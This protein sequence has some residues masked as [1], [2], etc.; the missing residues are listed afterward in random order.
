M[1]TETDP[2]RVTT[3]G[4]AMVPDAEPRPAAQGE[5]T[6]RLYAVRR[7]LVFGGGGVLT[8]LVL[9]AAGIAGLGIVEDFHGR[10]RQSFSEANAAI[11]YFLLQRDRAYAMSINSNDVIWHEQRADLEAKGAPLAPQFHAN[12][13]QLVVRAEGRTAVPWLVLGLPDH[14]VELTT[15]NA[16]L[17]MLDAYSAYTATAV[18][19]L[20]STG[21]SLT[22][23]YEP[24]GRLLAVSHMRDEAQLLQTLGVATRQQA[25]ALLLREEALVRHHPIRSGPIRSASASGRLISRY[26][27]NPLNGQPSLVGIL[28]LAEGSTP[29]FRRVVFESVDTMKARLAVSEHGNFAVLSNE[30]RLIFSNGQWSQAEATTAAAWTAG[31]SSKT[32][33]RHYEHGQFIVTGL[34]PDTDWVLLQAYDWGDIWDSQGTQLLITLATALLIVALLWALLL[35]MDRRIFAPALL[36][37]SRVYESDALSGAIISTAPIGLALIARDSGTPLL[38][39]QAAHNLISALRSATDATDPAPTLYADL[40]AH[41]RNTPASDAINLQWSAPEAP[42][43]RPIQLQVSLAPASYLEKPV[44]VCAFHDV[45]DQLEFADNLKRARADSERARELAEAANRAKSAF[46]ATMS[47]EI[48]TPLNG[49]LGHLELLARAELP[50]G[51]RERVERIRYSAD[52]LMS[53]ISDVLDFSKIEAGQLDLEC[54]PFALRPLL[55]SVAVLFAPEAARKGVKLY[56]ALEFPPYQQVSGDSHRI[57]QILNNLVGNAVKFTEAGRIL[58]RA[59]L[60]TNT[61]G[62]AHLCVEVIDSGIGISAEQLQQ[63]FQPFQQA[64]ASVSR[65]YG[66][67]GLGLALCQQLATA[68]GGR[69]EAD[70][71]P[72]VGSRFTLDIPVEALPLAPTPPPL[73]GQA[74]IVLAANQEWRG[75]FTRLLNGWGAEVRGLEHASA[76]AHDGAD[77]TLLIVGERSGFTAEEDAALRAHYDRILRLSGNGP[78]SPERQSD[79][80]IVLSAFVSDA[81]LQVLAPSLAAAPDATAHLQPVSG[82]TAM[83]VLLAEDN[84]VNRELMQQQLEELGL[85]VDAVE[86]GQLALAAFSAQTHAAVLTDINMP[87]MDGYALARALRHGGHRVPII[88]ITATA[89]A[90]ERER[91]LAAGIDELLLKPLN[92]ERL[93]AALVQLVTSSQAAPPLEP[94]P[95]QVK[96]ERAIPANIRQIF[97]DSG[98]QDVVELKRLWNLAQLPALRDRVHRVKGSLLMLGEE[99][100]A[101]EFSSAEQSLDDGQALDPGVFDELIQGFEACLDGYAQDLQ[102]GGA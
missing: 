96:S 74:I 43:Q 29:Y 22:Y 20:E 17:G 13:E 78:L 3:E 79:G 24:Q 23:A 32:T 1:T 46:L 100:L 16:Y 97:V 19:S 101:H 35:R 66:G 91:C 53:T 71:T 62:A 34:L 98:R 59:A 76:A 80:S 50:T 49:I 82:P 56:M 86:N 2:T 21:P 31:R 52:T 55:E 27:I 93:Q 75:E 54:A 90:S 12:G 57:R 87:V 51:Q 36:D 88:A 81:L 102:E 37:A 42:N 85:Q 92:L 18:T 83:R 94:P 28:T 48:R 63:L 70:S 8:G 14:P 67:S 73:S 44:W 26:G 64:D 15:L 68:L 41:G 61:E 7:R 58:L 40:A 99:A 60:R 5:T 11:S 30:G 25:F 10:Q 69:I 89:L 33:T 9:L 72:E 6:D 84:E 39:N 95:A 4:N 65:R 77:G 45:T 47:H 38:E